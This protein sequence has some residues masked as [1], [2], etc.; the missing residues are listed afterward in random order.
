MYVC[1]CVCACV[2][3]CAVLSTDHVATERQS[4]ANVTSGPAPATEWP[5]L[6]ST[7]VI[8]CHVLLRYDTFVTVCDNDVDASICDYLYGA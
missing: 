8:M 2:C 6:S 4:A 5:T 7:A 3:V 1:L